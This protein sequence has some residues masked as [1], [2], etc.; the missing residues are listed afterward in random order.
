MLATA[1]ARVESIVHDDVT[2][3]YA[4]QGDGPLVILCHGFPG[5]WQ[6][7]M[8]QMP[9]LA[10]A[11]YTAVA[12]D[13]RGYGGS[14]RPS[15]PDQYRLDKICED[16]AAVLSHFEQP[17]AIFIGTDF[18][19]AVLWYLARAHPDW[20]RAMVVMSVPFDFDYYGYMGQGRSL[21][22]PSVRFQAIASQQFLHAHHFQTPGLAEASLNKQPKAFLTRLFWA[23]SAKGKLVQRMSQSRPDMN[24]VDVLG[25]AEQSLPWSWM[26]EA[27][28]DVFA[29]SFTRTG[30]TG[31]LN[32]YRVCD[33]SWALNGELIGQSIDQPCLFISG[34]QD[35]VLVMSGADA[36]RP[37]Q[38]TVKQLYG[39]ELIDDAGHF[40][41][42]EQPDAVNRVLLQFL[43]QID[44]D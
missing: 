37:M 40:L 25:P 19:A 23:L 42:L 20:V 32:W 34:K 16:L 33:Q 35:P 29:D 13:M 22:A 28:L 11:G 14:S 15:E 26:S 17:S 43:A 38:D 27:L 41:Q 21:P 10:V 3:Q 36:L 1:T 31:A 7:W 18:G 39:I 6:S 4:K 8:H 5:L 2:I 24:Y 30:F 44:L 9:A 12:L